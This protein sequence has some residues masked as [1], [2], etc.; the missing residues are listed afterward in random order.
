[1]A[2]CPKCGHTNFETEDNIE[3]ATW[4]KLSAIVCCEC[5]TV[6]NFIESRKIRKE[7]IESIKKH[8]R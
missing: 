4:D 5:K 3:V 7:K 1:M 2:K 8:T 6:I